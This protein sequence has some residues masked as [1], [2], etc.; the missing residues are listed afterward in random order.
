MLDVLAAKLP[1]LVGGS[2]DLTPSNNTKFQE[3]GDFQQ[4]NPGGRYLRFGV[5]EHG[6]GA[7]LNGINLFGGL[8]AYGG[9]FLVF[10]DYMK[11]AIRIAAIS[12]IRSIFVF[13]HDSVGLGEDG[14]THQPIEHL[15]AMRATPNLTV[16]RPADAN[17]VV[18]AWRMAL[19]RKAQPHC[20]GI[21][22]SKCADAGR[23]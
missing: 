6:M 8:I 23:H 22:A 10:S 9:T 21:D 2:A 14:P 16:I 4:D 3:A 13:T 7:A 15:V 20:L 17:E 12:S 11:P 18:E 5:R 1:E 19:T